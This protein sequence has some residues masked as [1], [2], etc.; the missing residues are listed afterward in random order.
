MLTINNEYFVKDVKISKFDCKIPARF[1]IIR[2]TVDMEF[3]QVL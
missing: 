1:D 3:Q 2:F